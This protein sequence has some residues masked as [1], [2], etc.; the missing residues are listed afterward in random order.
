MAKSEIRNGKPGRDA[1]VFAPLTPA[2]ETAPPPGPFRIS[3]LGFPSDFAP[4]HLLRHFNRF[5]S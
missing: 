4:E 5:L 3:G 2:V 1:R